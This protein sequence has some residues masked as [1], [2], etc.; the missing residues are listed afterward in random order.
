MHP[1]QYCYSSFKPLYFF[2]VSFKDYKVVTT[3]RHMCFNLY[4]LHATTPTKSR[5]TCFVK[6]LAR[7]HFFGFSA[8]GLVGLKKLVVLRKSF[9]FYFLMN[10]LITLHNMAK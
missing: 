6:K 8:L 5:K 9:H 10:N 4:V 1:V 3:V 7:E 2:K